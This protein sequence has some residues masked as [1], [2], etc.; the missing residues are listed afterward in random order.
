MSWKCHGFNFKILIPQSAHS[1]DVVKVKVTIKE[2]LIN[3]TKAKTN[4]QKLRQIYK[5]VSSH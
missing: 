1:N 2:L 4:K 5:H 3:I